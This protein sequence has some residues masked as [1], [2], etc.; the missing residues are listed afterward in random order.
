[1]LK[2]RQPDSRLFRLGTQS[3]YSRAQMGYMECIIDLI[4]WFASPVFLT[5]E[6]AHDTG[7]AE[8]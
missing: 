6:Q 7:L 8:L 4:P 3:G 1:M 2:L 5:A